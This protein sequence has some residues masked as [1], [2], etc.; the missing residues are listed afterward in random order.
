MHR[1]LGTTGSEA[2]AAGRCI[3]DFSN[4]TNLPAQAP[5]NNN[6][7]IEEFRLR[8][9]LCEINSVRKVSKEGRMR[10]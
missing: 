1:F 6:K 3:S 8:E 5:I 2:I 9:A 7:T 4:S 10:V